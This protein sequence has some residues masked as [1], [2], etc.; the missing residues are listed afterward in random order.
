MNWLQLFGHEAPPPPP[1]VIA[2]RAP[3]RG[4][5]AKHAASLSHR[6]RTAAHV[7]RLNDI[8]AYLVGREPQSAATLHA[9]FGGAKPTMH[10]NLLELVEAGRLRTWGMRP[11]LWGHP[12]TEYDVPDEQVG[13]R[14][15]S[16]AHVLEILADGLW[17]TTP[18]VHAAL[19]K[20]RRRHIDQSNVSHTLARLARRGFL[21]SSRLGN[22]PF[23]WKRQLHKDIH[24]G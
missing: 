11:K 16:E 19:E 6:T 2:E 24:H 15:F 13:A 4:E 14:A 7:A 12:D 1:A 3:T 10:A 21:V 9:H 20:K 18:D 22:N 23:N 17:H 8:V 5:K